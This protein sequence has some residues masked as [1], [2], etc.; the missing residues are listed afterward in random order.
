MELLREILDPEFLFRNA[1]DTSVLV[2]L[3]APVVGAFL[4]LRRMIFLGVALPQISSTGIALALSLHVWYGHY[5]GGHGAEER[6]LAFIGSIGFALVA[7]CVLAFLDRHRRGSPEGRIGTAYVVSIAISILLLA[8]CPQA[9]RGWLDLFKGQIFAI[10]TSDLVATAVTMLLVV[11][12]LLAFRNPL[13][14]VSFDRDLALVLKRNVLFWDVL[15]YL[16]VGLAISVAV[17]SVGPLM[18]F[19]FM[20][21]PPLIAHLFAA[22][23]RQFILIASA[24]GGVIALAG[25]CVAYKYDLPGGPTDVALLGALYALVFTGKKMATMTRRWRMAKDAAETAD[26]TA[27]KGPL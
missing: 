8:K 11:G 5:D 9:E 21:V 6:V 18:T 19:G 10:K 20:L 26:A 3:A 13:L 14:L 4:V 16:L 15:L 1:V 17:I 27:V 2:G 25:F 7:V 24:I 22:N 12:A 23:M